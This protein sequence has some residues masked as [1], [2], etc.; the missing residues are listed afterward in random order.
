M[1]C[2]RQLDEFSF[3]PQQVPDGP[4]IPATRL[5]NAAQPLNVQLLQ[6][7][8]SAL[9]SFVTVI[10]HSAVHRHVSVARIQELVSQRLTQRYTVGG[11]VTQHACQE[12]EC[13]GA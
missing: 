3:P 1:G 2:L 7:H 6:L 10:S 5:A 8:C 4:C 11:G 13:C 12:R 9:G